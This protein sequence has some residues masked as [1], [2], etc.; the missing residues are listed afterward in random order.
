LLISGYQTGTVDQQWIGTNMGFVRSARFTRRRKV[1]DDWARRMI[2]IKK[3]LDLPIN[4]APEQKIADA[5]PVRQVALIGF[6]Y[7]GMK[8]TMAVQEGDRVKRGSLLFTD[9]KTDGVRYTSPAG[10]VV[11]EINR[12]ERRVFQ[13]VV[14]DV[15]DD[16]QAEV[17]P[18]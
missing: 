7:V 12:G 1:S 6:D 4:G 2:K 11:R 13:S 8:P 18:L 17:R 9:K 15:D 14:V 16:E 3:G 10:G 5:K